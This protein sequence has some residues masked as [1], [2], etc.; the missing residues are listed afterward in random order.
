[1]ASK[2]AKRGGNDTGHSESVIGLTLP[3]GTLYSGT[4]I[5]GVPEGNG[6]VKFIGAAW[7]KGK[8]IN[9]EPRGPGSI[10]L[11]TGETIFGEFSDN[12]FVGE[13]AKG[14]RTE[15]IKF[16][17]QKGRLT[18][19]LNENKKVPEP[20]PK[21]EPEPEPE[22]PEPEEIIEEIPEPEPEPEPVVVQKKTPPQKPPSEYGVR[23]YA[24]GKYMGE[25]RNG[26]RDG[27]G[28]FVRNDGTVFLGDFS[29]DRPHGNM[30]V[31]D[32]EGNV[33]FEGEYRNGEMHYGTLKLGNRTY[34]GQFKRGVFHGLGKFTGSDGVTIE[35]VFH[36]GR[37]IGPIKDPTKPA[38]WKNAIP[39]SEKSE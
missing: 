38:T 14:R 13:R 24:D 19:I 39:V 37:Y 27:K 12:V 8:F 21:P 35:G 2:G 17:V 7:F 28:R 32:P 6:V 18:R 33:S 30:T 22:I 1:M 23:E 34:V 36:F 29:N 4:V 15:V 11:N 9:G 3:N 31:T 16:T 10:R 5:D 20:P 26:K 25:F